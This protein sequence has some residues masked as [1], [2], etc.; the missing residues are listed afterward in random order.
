MIE[1][2]RPVNPQPKFKVVLAY[3]VTAFVQDTAPQARNR[4]RTV[5]DRLRPMVPKH[6]RGQYPVDPIDFPHPADKQ[7][8]HKANQHPT[9]FYFLGLASRNTADKVMD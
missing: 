4:W 6:D 7:R 9:A 2:G 5:A 8:V 3:I 1:H